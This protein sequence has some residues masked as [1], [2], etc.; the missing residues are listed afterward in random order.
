MGLTLTEKILA[1]ASGLDQVVPGDIVNAEIDV[2]MIHDSLGILTV[3]SFN[4]LPIGNVWDSSRVLVIFDHKVPATNA[5]VADSQATIRRFVKEQGIKNF[6]DIGRGGIC[7]Q[8]F[9]E[10]GH[11]KPGEVVVGADSHTTTHGALGAFAVGIGSTEMAGVFATGELWFK[12]PETISVVLEGILGEAVMGKDVIMYLIG[13]LGVSGASYK[14][15][16][17]SGQ[18]IDNLSVAGR[19]SVCNMAAEMGAKNA[20]IE[21]D[22]KILEYL[23]VRVK[24]KIPFLKKDIDSI[25]S[26][27]KVMDCSDIEPLVASPS[28]PDNVKSVAD[29]EGI[30]IDQAFLGSCTN[31]RLE[32]LRSAAKI[33]RERKIS[34]SV[35]CVVIPGSQEV[36]AQAMKEGLL[37]IFHNA[38]ASV[39]APSCGPCTGAD[40]GILGPDEICIATTNRNFTGRMGDPSSKVYLANPYTVAASA[41]TGQICDPRPFL[42]GDV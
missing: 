37:E 21:P 38:G 30:E 26:L 11:V 12:V 15:V 19:L 18:V 41:I 2:A 31:G 23:R 8:V 29:V 4:E 24:G 3:Q 22:S 1:R 25:Y 10:K 28:S 20:I 6:Y 36:M 5:L 40:K 33:F 27:E 14:A 9:H 42:R 39:N 35:R 16:E 7:H 34:D 13:K 17:F 32:D